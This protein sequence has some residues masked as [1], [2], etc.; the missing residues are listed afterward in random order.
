VRK[1]GIMQCEVGEGGREGVER[2][3]EFYAQN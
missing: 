3:V 2:L 1:G